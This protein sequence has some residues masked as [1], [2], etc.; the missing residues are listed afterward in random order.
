MLE[1]A[2][3]RTPTPQAKHSGETSPFSGYWNLRGETGERHEKIHRLQD[4]LIKQ[5]PVEKVE[6]ELAL[7]YF[8]ALAKLA[9]QRIQPLTDFPL[10]EGVRALDHGTLFFRFTFPPFGKSDQILGGVNE[11]RRMIE[12]LPIR[13]EVRPHSAAASVKSQTKP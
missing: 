11:I 5:R 1:E 9:S 10:L 7:G 13:R 6:K 4:I 8:D 2:R 3:A 12:A